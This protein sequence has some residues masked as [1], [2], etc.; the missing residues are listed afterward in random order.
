MLILLS[1][2]KSQNFDISLKTEAQSQPVFLNETQKLVK[3][4]QKLKPSELGELMSISANLSELN[5]KRFQ[6]FELPFTN[7][8]ARQAALVFTGDVYRGLDAASFSDSELEYAQ[9]HLRILSGLYGM[10]KPLDLMQAYRLEMKIKLKYRQKK[11]LYE[12]W[13]DKIT[14][15]INKEINLQAHNAVVNLASNEYFKAIQSPKIKAPLITPIFKEFKNNEYKII[16]IFAKRARGLMANYILKNK[17]EDIESIKNFT[18]EGYNFD[19][20]LSDET[21]F[22][23]TRNQV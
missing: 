9:N 6:E 14:K 21:N 2:A 8:N 11:N 1:P 15:E 12:F 17:I 22:V 19:Q 10:L 5:F 3:V 4:A 13:G 7:Q 18:T 16:A 20:N 23:F